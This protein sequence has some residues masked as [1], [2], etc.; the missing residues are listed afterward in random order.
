M[1]CL[2]LRL[3]LDRDEPRQGLRFVL[4]L[5]P[6]EVRGWGVPNLKLYN[7]QKPKIPVFRYRIVLLG[8]FIQL[9]LGL[10]DIFGPVYP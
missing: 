7:V 10:F 9:D 2:L 8:Y 6:R 5:L 4:M 3:L 1:L